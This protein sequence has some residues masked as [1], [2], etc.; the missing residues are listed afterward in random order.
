MNHNIGLIKMDYINFYLNL[1]FIKVLS[2]ILKL[3]K[4][5][6]TSLAGKIVL[7]VNK[8]FLRTSQYFV[9]KA[10]INITGTNGKT[11]SSNIISS[12]LKSSNEKVVSNFLGANMLNGIATAIGKDLSIFKKADYFVFES[13]EAYLTKLY[14]E[15]NAN[16]LLVTNLFRDQLD[17]YGEL[18]ST[19]EKINEAIVKNKN[20]ILLLNADD[21]MVAKLGDNKEN[22]VIYY[23]FK[24]VILENNQNYKNLSP[25]ESISC[26]CGSEYRYNKIFYSHLGH[27]YCSN[28]QNVRPKVKYE[29]ECKIDN[30]GIVITVNNKT[31]KSNL[32]GTYNAYNV[33]SAICLCLEF[34]IDE[35]IIQ[36][37]LD[38]YNAVFGRNEKIKINKTNV[39]INLIK[40]PTGASEVLDSIKNKKNT[41]LLLILNDNYAD[42][43]DVSW[44]WDTNFEL[45]NNFKNDIYVSGKRAYDLA[46]RLKYA[47]ID[48]KLIHIEPNIKKALKIS[49]KLC[50]NNNELSILPTYTGLLELKK[51]TH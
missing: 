42:G 12:I 3:F 26:N 39:S 20:L 49:I 5:N 15:I 41:K 31:F 36:K 27:Y 30:N 37:A 34:N 46:L 45:L 23:G 9:K 51:I 17:R 21:P 28:C 47:N 18:N 43:R 16:Y 7:K 2:Q 24:N 32:T 1:I 25:K 14:D 6:A 4:Y 29:A 10:I 40:N 8:N 48:T 38:N 13:D 35:K 19:F 50:D 22:K 33:L 44:I 11:T